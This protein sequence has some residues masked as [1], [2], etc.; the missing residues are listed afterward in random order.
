MTNILAL[1]NSA[2]GVDS[3]MEGLWDV[4]KGFSGRSRDER[5]R[6]KQTLAYAKDKSLFN[7]QAVFS[8]PQAWD[9]G[10]PVVALS[11]YTLTEVEYVSHWIGFRKPQDSTAFFTFARPPEVQPHWHY[12]EPNSY[13]VMLSMY[14]QFR[15]VVPPTPKALLPWN[16]I[17][18][19]K[20]FVLFDADW[21]AVPRD[22]Y[23]LERVNQ[24]QFRIVAH[25]DLTPQ[26]RM[27][28]ELIAHG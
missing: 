18:R 22:P 14:A 3:P 4:Y 2:I 27:L 28:M 26:E 19:K 13:Q 21:K 5:K 15:T 17:T 9:K 24:N 8:L 6:M 11:P 7:A 1:V 20:L 10:L 12:D 23:L 16:P 25:W